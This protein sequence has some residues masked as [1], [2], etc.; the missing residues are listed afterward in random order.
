MLPEVW[1]LAVGYALF[2]L[3]TLLLYSWDK[4]AAMRGKRRIRERTL[5]LW[6]LCGGWPGAWLGQ[7]GLRHKSQ[8]GRF[9]RVFWL[10]VIAN[11]AGV[12]ALWLSRLT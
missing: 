10:T 7:Y 6:A 8:K 2:S 5:H 11:V 12:I 3:I 1:A 4:R 9:R